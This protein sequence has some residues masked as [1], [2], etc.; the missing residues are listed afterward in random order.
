MT[1]RVRRLLAAAF[2]F[3]AGL[4]L[5]ILPWSGFWDRNLLLEW[6]GALYELTRSGYVRGAVSG[7]GIVNLWVGIVEVFEAWQP[8]P[9]E[10]AAGVLSPLDEARRG[11][12]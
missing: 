12:A 4:V 6:S 7:L 8:V 1:L 3:E 2:F 5:L 10:D 11:R 9:D